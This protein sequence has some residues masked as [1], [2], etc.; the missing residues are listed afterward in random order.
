MAAP[1][2]GARVRN[3]ECALSFAGPRSPGGLL[4]GLRDLQALGPAEAAAQGRTG[5]FVR[6]RETE[7]PADDARGGTEEAPGAAGEGEAP[8]ELAIGTA[9]GFSGGGGG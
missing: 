6:I 7:I 9:G 1:A 4:V 3:A 8:K 2:A 5:L